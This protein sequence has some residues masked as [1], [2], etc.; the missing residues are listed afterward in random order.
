MIIRATQKKMMSK[1]GQH[2]VGRIV[3]LAGPRVWSGQPIVLNG[4]SC[5]L[6]QVSSTSVSC[7]SAP[8]HAARASASPRDTIV[9]PHAAQY[10]AGIRWPHQSCREMHQSW[11]FVIQS[12]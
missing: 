6:N 5:E 9:S 10:Q 11:M 1:A 7:S 2:Q 4:Q 8:P 3:A 12:K